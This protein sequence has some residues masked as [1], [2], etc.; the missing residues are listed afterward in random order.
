MILL[1]MY[2]AARQ[3][4]LAWIFGIIASVLSIFLFY[5][6]NYWGSMFLNAVYCIQGVFGYFNWKFV[7]EGKKVRN[8]LSVFLQLWAV[9]ILT[10]FAY[11]L[12]QIIRRN[13][14]LELNLYDCILAVL[15]IYATWLEVKKEMACWNIWILANLG[16]AVLY[17]VSASSGSMYLYAALMLLLAVF[18]MMAKRQWQASL[19]E[20][21]S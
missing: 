1:Y 21:Q 17:F 2:F 8:S 9:L 13:A 14:S 12:Y 20:T 6:Q 15:S 10:F 3:K 11:Q 18:S 16:Y 19:S 5:Y 4:P 7:L